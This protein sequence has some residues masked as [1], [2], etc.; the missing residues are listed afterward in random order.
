MAGIGNKVRLKD[1]TVGIIK[2]VTNGNYLLITAEGKAR[3]ATPEDI[4]DIL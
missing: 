3:W 2:Q 1:G 4:Q